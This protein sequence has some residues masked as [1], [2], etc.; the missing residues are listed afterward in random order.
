MD[1][2]PTQHSAPHRFVFR[3]GWPRV[4]WRLGRFVNRHKD[5]FTNRWH[6]RAFDG[7]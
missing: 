4:L 7:R 6:W 3:H 1:A 2:E 5:P